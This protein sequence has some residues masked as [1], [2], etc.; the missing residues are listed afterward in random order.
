MVAYLLNLVYGLL[1]LVLS[2]GILYSAI[3]YGK[4]REGWR[5]K[6]WGHV[7]KLPRTHASK[8]IWFHAVSV[9]EVNLLNPLLGA[10]REALPDLE[11]IVTTTTK[12][13]Y[14]LA[15][16][17]FGA[18]HTVCYCPLDFSWAVN[19]ALHRF[20]PDLLVLVELELWPNLLLAAR[21]Q[22]VPVAIVNG[23]LSDKSTR[24]Y[25][26]LRNWLPG[27]T[28]Q[29]MDCITAVAA[30]SQTCADRFR[31]IGLAPQRITNTGSIKFD[32]AQMDRE[33]ELTVRLRRLAGIRPNQPVFVAGS[34]QAPEEQ[35]ALQ[36]YAALVP[37]HPQLRLLLVPRHPERAGEVAQLLDASGF[38][39]KRRTEI[40]DDHP[41]DDNS[42]LL[43]DTV[44]ELGGWWGC[45]RIGFVGGSL[46]SRGGQNML[47]PAALGVATCFGPN[48]R[49]FRDIVGLLL[50]SEAAVVVAD[51]DEMRRFAARCL[52]DPAYARELGQRARHV[53]QSHGGATE[54][55]VAELVR[56]LGR[57]AG[58]MAEKPGNL[59]Y[60]R[61]A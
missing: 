50:E 24:G 25:L 48:T 37:R 30:Q 10:M 27:I 47:E 3:R 13:G 18:Q 45:A 19:N 36:V 23:R 53:V 1:L 26:R 57:T 15:C 59:D 43:V 4:Y 60:R 44:G 35:F 34:T 22:G 7:P 2:P 49:N 11:V 14:Q 40:D 52:D 20:R 31:Q 42:I 61:S 16:R 9:G 54:A 39:W 58:P 6:L 28:T 17:R 8:R 41:V 21:Q 55:T 12:T 5:E 33:N 32:G 29:I 38:S 51:D 46:G 56:L